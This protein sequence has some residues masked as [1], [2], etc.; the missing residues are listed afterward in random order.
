[1]IHLVPVRCRVV[2]RPR[3]ETS[4]LRPFRHRSFA[5]LWVGAFVSNIGTWMET[6]AIGIYVTQVTGQAAWTGLVAAA[7]FVPTA[8]LGSVGGALADRFERRRLL[9]AG[10]LLSAFWA[11]VLTFLF[12]IGEPAP[13]VVTLIVLLGGITMALAFPSYQAML[14]D[15]VPT[16]DL[17]AAIAL[18]S[19][20]WNLGRV[21]GPLLAGIVISL[22]G[23]AWALGINAVSFFAVVFVL[24]GFRL[25]RPKPAVDGLWASILTGVRFVRREPGLRLVVGTMSL[26]TLLAAPFIALVPAMAIEVLDAGTAGTSVLV[27]AQGIGAVTMAVAMGPLAERF[28][29]RRVLVSVVA[30]L[31][32][33]L[34]AYAY[35]PSL[36]VSALTIFAVGFLYLGALS[37]FTTIAQLRAPAHLR[38]RVLGV[39][40]VI[41]GAL[42]PLG[43]VIQGRI[44]DSVGLRA[45]TAGAA[46]L[47]GAVLLAVRLW[48]P[49]ITDVLDEPVTVDEATVAASTPADALSA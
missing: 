27:T 47:M 14:P 42:Y 18:S 6:V 5:A 25:P 24:L 9:L 40:M 49:R 13:A 7:G 16:E 11:G 10:N 1:M 31:P 30:L 29:P 26:N 32:L 21:I 37:S 4:P 35:A 39:N 36:A 3:F 2:A 23:F 41:L 8:L 33:A 43:S 45:T 15:L 22:G 46:I 38:G 28:G 12:V 17:M 48:R 20:Q 34:V 44:A 19:A